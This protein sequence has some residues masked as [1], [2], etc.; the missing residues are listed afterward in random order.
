[1]P[2]PIPEAW[3][4]DVIRILRTCDPRLIEWTTPAR[5]RWEA[6]TFGDAEKHDAEGAM[7]AALERDDVT[8]NETTSY[9]G[10]AGTYEFMF[11]FRDRPMYG[12]V[13]LYDDR[14]RILILSA[15]KPKRPTL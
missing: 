4:R 6:D 12:K 8:G 13:A 15:H 10:Q 14:L 1:M 2:E 5:Q 11:S 7:I 3:R 9:P